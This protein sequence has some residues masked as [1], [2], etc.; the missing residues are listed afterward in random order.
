MAAIFGSH[1]FSHLAIIPFH[2][3]IDYHQNA[4]MKGLID[5]WP[6]R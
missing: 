3:G 4:L 1:V 6:I 5:K 2:S